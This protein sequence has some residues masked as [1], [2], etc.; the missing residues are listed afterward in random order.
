VELGAVKKSKG[1]RSVRPS[2]MRYR[3]I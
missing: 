1:K 3:D 2:D